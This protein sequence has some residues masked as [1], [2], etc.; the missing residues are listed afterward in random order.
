MS[1]PLNSCNENMVLHS[2]YV[3]LILIEI[4]LKT[5]LAILNIVYLEEKL[6]NT[7]RRKYVLFY[8]ARNL[9]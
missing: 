8:S 4:G 7:L 3:Y 1:E 5:I 6:Q 9:S 2:G